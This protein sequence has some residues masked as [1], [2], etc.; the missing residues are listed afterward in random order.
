LFN[1]IISYTPTL[2]SRKYRF[3]NSTILFKN[4][5]KPNYF[6][7]RNYKLFKNHQKKN[8]N[9]LLKSF[10]QKK[11]PFTR[12]GK[13]RFF[14]FKFVQSNFYFFKLSINP[15]RKVNFLKTPSNKIKNYSNILFKNTKL[16][17]NYSTNKFY[18]SL[19]KSFIFLNFFT[20]TRLS[21]NKSIPF[22]AT[23]SFTKF[24]LNF[25]SFIYTF[26]FLTNNLKNFSFITSA[27]K[28]LYSFAYKN[29]LNKIILRRYLK[30]TKTLNYIFYKPSLQQTKSNFTSNLPRFS[31][32]G[33]HISS[34]N[35]GVSNPN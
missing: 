20:H 4:F 13:F 32:T 11:S 9:P 33:S 8:L 2:I 5:P 6:V 15:L 28:H 1:K 19:H 22:I 35:F 26:R 23:K 34:S 27:R 30:S 17:K 25:N 31:F 3:S 7:F 14:K 29:D 12:F 16:I 10:F 21:L 18:S 24:V